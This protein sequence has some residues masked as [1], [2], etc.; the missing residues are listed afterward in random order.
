MKIKHKTKYRVYKVQNKVF[1]KHA[2]LKTIA[3]AISQD[4]IG[5]KRKVEKAKYF[6]NHQKIVKIV[7]SWL[8]YKI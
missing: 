6:K 7:F 8:Q 5:R 3:L 4:H 2:K 1:F